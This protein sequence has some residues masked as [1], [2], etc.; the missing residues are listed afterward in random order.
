MTET[1]TKMEP[2]KTDFFRRLYLNSGNPQRSAWFW[3]M[4]AALTSSFQSMLFMLVLTRFGEIEAA[5][6]IA[7]GFAAA[8][9]AMTVGKFGVR[10]FQVTDVTEKYHFRDYRN[11]RVLTVAAMVVFT[12]IYC[13]FNVV[14]R[15]YVPVKTATVALLCI[16]KMI[17]SAEDV[18]HGR[19]QQLGRLDIS[20]KIWATRNILFII[21]FILCYFWLRD[22]IVSLLISIVTTLVLSLLLNRIPRGEYRISPASKDTGKTKALLVE[23]IPVAFATF[24]L[25]YIS[26]APKYIIDSVVSD[27][28]QTYFNILF[29]VI[30]IVTLLSNFMFNP[31]LN[32]MAIWRE[33]GEH[34]KL[35]KRVVR[36]IA[37][38]AGIVAVGVLFAEAI[39]TQLLGWIYGVSL[40][41][42][43]AEVDLML[44][45]GGLIA[46]L[47]L[48]YLII[49]LLRKQAIFY[50]IFTA[51]SLVLVSTGKNILRSYEL[52]G[53]CCFYIGILLLADIAMFLCVFVLIR[54]ERREAQHISGKP[55]EPQAAPESDGAEM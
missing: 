54:K 4:M 17:E 29:M 6:Y 26:N 40:A 37:A 2:T 16:Y 45:A 5:S 32:R 22:L 7:I 35:L 11:M 21:E 24:L 42:Y 25:M 53:L 49:I 13:G 3:N 9:L 8:N 23:C 47:N 39:G 18:W 44:I 51:V 52:R 15:Q 30:Y 28:E 38:V 1:E 50:V 48:L 36:L 46:I 27:Q 34:A 12:L 20:A 55:N 31:V 41:D 19:L 33:H 10:N 43:H 14:F